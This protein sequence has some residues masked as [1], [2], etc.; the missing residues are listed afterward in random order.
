MVGATPP[1]SAN[2]A[3]YLSVESV[4][5]D[6]T[7]NHVAVTGRMYQ[8]E[9]FR[10]TGLIIP[11]D[12]DPS[13]TDAVLD[14]ASKAISALGVRTGCFHTEIKVTNN[15]LRVIEVNGRIGGFVA[16]VLALAA[17]GVNFFEISQRVALGESLEF[18]QVVPTEGVGYVIVEQ[19]PLWATSVESVDGLD[20][21]AEYPGVASV[22][23]SRQPGDPVD[24]RKG[25]HEYVWSVL[26]NAPDHEGVLGL[27]RFIDREVAVTY[28]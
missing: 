16:E 2:F 7:I 27:Q 1:P 23:L 11:S 17:P 8:V 13:V 10:E 12:F 24:W 3:D 9:P 26:G 18:P 28:A 21:L 5:V 14:L 4:V 20:R 19:P 6:G 25:S 22:F 15:G